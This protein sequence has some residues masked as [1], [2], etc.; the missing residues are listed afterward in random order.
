M[1]H[2]KNAHSTSP[3]HLSAQEESSSSEANDFS[4]SNVLVADDNRA[5]RLILTRQFKKVGCLF[6]VVAD[7]QE[8]LDAMKE[9]HFDA[10]FIDC[11]MPRVSGYEFVDIVR[12]QEATDDKRTRYHPI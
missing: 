12:N 6:K 11:H 5:N 2:T 3:E 7:G 8:A 1:G 10:F 9:E 4:L